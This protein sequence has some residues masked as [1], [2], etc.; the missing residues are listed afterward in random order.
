MKGAEYDF[1]LKTLKVYVYNVLPWPKKNNLFIVSVENILL[2]L[3]GPNE[4]S[5]I[6]TLHYCF[7]WAPSNIISFKILLDKVI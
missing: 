7:H 2:S 5:I 1:G 6:V 4:I 3:Q